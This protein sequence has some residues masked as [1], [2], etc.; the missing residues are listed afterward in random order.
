MKNH[1]TLFIYNN[2]RRIDAIHNFA[3]NILFRDMQCNYPCVLGIC[4]TIDRIKTEGASIGRY[5]DGEFRLC[6]GKSIRFQPASKELTRRLIEILHS[7]SNGFY[8]AI[9]P[10]SDSPRWRHIHVRNWRVTAKLG[11]QVR[12]SSL[13]SHPQISTIQTP[14]E[15]HSYIRTVK[16]IWENRDVV[17]IANHEV[18][19]TTSTDGL[20]DNVKSLT[21]ITVPDKNAFNDYQEI[22]QNARTRPINSLFLIACGPTATI[23]AYDLN[24]LGYSAIDIGH[25]PMTHQKQLEKF[26]CQ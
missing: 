21:T 25:L 7:K 20:V 3:S 16:S 18:H 10:L 1:I 19:D 2:F 4:E 8:A 17:L 24:K 12:L 23:L 13:I 9:L 15:Y 22:L 5:G 14:A 11:G 6:R 26:N